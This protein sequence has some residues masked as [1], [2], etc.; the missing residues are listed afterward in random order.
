MHQIQR[1]HP[2]N[3]IGG[4]VIRVRGHLCYSQPRAALRKMVISY[5]LLIRL[6]RIH[7]TDHLYQLTETIL[8]LGF[9]F[10]T[11]FLFRICELEMELPLVYFQCNVKAITA[12]LASRYAR[13]SDARRMLRCSTRILTEIGLG[14]P[15]EFFVAPPG[16]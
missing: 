14:M 16:S 5:D 13:S 2:I 1:S 15:E 12:R 11:L 7:S 10:S 3:Q 6:S 8:F 9:V 4:E